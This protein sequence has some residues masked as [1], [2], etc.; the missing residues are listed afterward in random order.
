MHAVPDDT[1]EAMATCMMAS[2]G[3][4]PE[5][6]SDEWENIFTPPAPNSKPQ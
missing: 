3:P 4:E 5:D 2:I 6:L 1:S